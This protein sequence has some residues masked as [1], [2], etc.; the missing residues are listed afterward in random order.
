VCMSTMITDTRH[1]CQMNLCC[2]PGQRTLIA[3]AV[4]C[5]GRKFDETGDRQSW[6]PQTVIPALVGVVFC[7]FSPNIG[8][9]EGAEA[10]ARA[11]RIARCPP[12]PT[13]LQTASDLSDPE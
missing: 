2:A 3:R 11:C 5:L 4:A 1:S 7:V 6:C 13:G 10:A 8:P 9:S 12:T